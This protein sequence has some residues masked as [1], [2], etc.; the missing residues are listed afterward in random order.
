MTFRRSPGKYLISQKRYGFSLPSTHN[1]DGLDNELSQV[2]SEGR[3]G[4]KAVV[5]G[6]SGIW[7]EL[8]SNG[9]SICRRTPEGRCL[10]DSTRCFHKV[11]VQ[12]EASPSS[13]DQARTK[14][15][16][17]SGAN[18]S[19]KKVNSMA[20]N[21]TAQV[22]EIAVVARCVANGDL[23]RKIQ[24]PAKGEILELQETLNNMIDN[25]RTFA[26]EVTRVAREFNQ[27]RVPRGLLNLL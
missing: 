2:G 17:Y 19:V 15:V 12:S 4:G 26:T 21:L 7:A 10:S 11:D 13:V 5:P 23:S 14:S 9:E 20:W 1:K 22:R 6:V 24:R 3:L 27:I 16:Q 25:L 8:T 18:C